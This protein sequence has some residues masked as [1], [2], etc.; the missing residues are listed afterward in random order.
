MQL[1][2][3]PVFFPPLTSPQGGDKKKAVILS[4]VA[5]KITAKKIFSPPSA[6]KQQD[7]TAGRAD[8][9]SGHNRIFNFICDCPNIRRRLKS[10]FFNPPLML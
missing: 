3:H 8:G 9:F 10:T 7:Y 5:V 4:A 1:P 2:L 6:A